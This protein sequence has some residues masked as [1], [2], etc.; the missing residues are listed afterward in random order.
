MAHGP[1]QDG[2]SFPNGLQ[3]G[4]GQIFARFPV[5]NGSAGMGLEAERERTAKALNGL[6]DFDRFGGDVHADAVT[7]Q[8]GDVKLVIAR[9]GV[10]KVGTEVLA[11]RRLLATTYQ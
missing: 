4:G 8:D 5:A 3:G 7:G 6:E 11:E 9:H 10:G 1:E 2:V